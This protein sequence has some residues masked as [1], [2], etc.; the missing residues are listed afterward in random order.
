[1]RTD[2]T[3]Q[4]PRPGMVQRFVTERE[5]EAYIDEGWARRQASNE[6]DKK[7]RDKFN[8]EICDTMYLVEIPEAEYKNHVEKHM[9]GERTKL[10]TRSLKEE[11]EDARRMESGK[12]PRKTA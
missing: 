4:K 7:F 6:K 5:V 1:M 8:D 10:Q 11:S 3:D 9:G 2:Y 12:R